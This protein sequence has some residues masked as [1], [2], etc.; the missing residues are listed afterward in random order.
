M[1]SISGGDKDKSLQTDMHWTDEQEPPDTIVSWLPH[2]EVGRRVMFIQ[3]FSSRM[4]AI[5]QRQNLI[6]EDKY[7]HSDPR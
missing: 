2:T 6:D 5:W 1:A 7:G 4:T 3:I